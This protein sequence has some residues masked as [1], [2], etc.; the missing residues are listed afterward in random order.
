MNEDD[1]GRIGSRSGS[2]MNREEKM[3]RD[4]QQ[5]NRRS[6]DEDREANR[7]RFASVARVGE[8]ENFIRGLVALSVEP[9]RKLRPCTPTS[10]VHIFMHQQG[11]EIR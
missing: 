7:Q 9:M 5:E 10:A 1:G 4:D 2:H 3:S 11:G 8:A 6:E